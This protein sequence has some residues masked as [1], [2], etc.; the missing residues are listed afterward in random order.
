MDIRKIKKAT[1]KSTE[2]KWS[3]EA[4][5]A[6]NLTRIGLP[7]SDIEE[8]QGKYRTYVPSVP[9]TC[10]M[11]ARGVTA[12]VLMFERYGKRT[13]LVVPNENYDME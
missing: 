4:I 12:S 7:P 13:F 9:C 6:R 10:F 5:S 2:G 8:V 3:K 11:V 1:L